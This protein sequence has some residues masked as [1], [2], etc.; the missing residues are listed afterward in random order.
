MATVS[1]VPYAM[2]SYLTGFLLSSTGRFIGWGTGSTIATRNHTGL[3]TE[4]RSSSNDGT[5]NTRVSGTRS[6][7][8]ITHTNDT[9]MVSGSLFVHVDDSPQTVTETA[10]FD[11]DG[12]SGNLGSPPNGGVMVLK[13]T[14]NGITLNP[15]DGITINH[16]L[17]FG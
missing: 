1:V 16:R 14:W 6:V 7:S 12:S 2:L 15:G 5:N 17:T 4:I 9:Y 8:T 13:T 10:V 3:E 11:E